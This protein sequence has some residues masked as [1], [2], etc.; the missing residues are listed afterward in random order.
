MNYAFGTQFLSSQGRCTSGIYFTLQ[1]LPDHLAQ[2]K[3]GVKW[4]L[5]LDTEGLFGAERMQHDNVDEYD[6]KIVL[7]AMLA[8]DMLIINVSGEIK[9]NM[10]KLL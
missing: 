6:R 2:N 7:F 5:M 1:K 9:S 4:I 10:I 3:A 8:S